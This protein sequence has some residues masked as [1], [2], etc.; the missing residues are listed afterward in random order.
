MFLGCVGLHDIFRV[1]I[2]T[3]LVLIVTFSRCVDLESASGQRVWILMTFSGCF[4]LDDIFGCVNVCDICGC[5]DLDDIFGMLIMMFL[6][7]VV[8]DDIYW[9]CG[10]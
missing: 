4:D 5:V 6:G 10:S 7:C 1:Y 2:M 8:F 9:M 3:F